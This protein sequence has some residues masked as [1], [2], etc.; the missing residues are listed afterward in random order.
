MKLISRYPVQWD[1]TTTGM[2][3][4]RGRQQVFTYFYLLLLTC[5]IINHLTLPKSIPSSAC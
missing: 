2:Y 5:P 3:N 4:D 1:T